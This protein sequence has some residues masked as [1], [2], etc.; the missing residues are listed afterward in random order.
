MWGGSAWV[1][2]IWGEMELDK[3]IIKNIYGLKT[4]D[5][6]SNLNHVAKCSV[7]ENPQSA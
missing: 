6:C 5:P 1:L 4:Q 2:F 7:R 3:T